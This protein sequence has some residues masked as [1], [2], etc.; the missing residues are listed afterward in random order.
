MRLDR[1][2]LACDDN[3]DFC[4]YFHAVSL[5]WKKIVNVKPTLFYIGDEHNKKL[6][7]FLGDIIIF[8]PLKDIPTPFQ[9][10][11]IRLLG[12]CL[13]EDISIISDMDILPLSNDYFQKSIKEYNKNNFIIYRPF[14]KIPEG[15][16]KNYHKQEVP[17]C[18]NAAHG[19]TWREIFKVSDIDQI[20]ETLKIWWKKD[21]R[22]TADQRILHQYLNSWENNSKNCIY[23]GDKKTNFKR[24]DRKN[25]LSIRSAAFIGNLSKFTDFH[26]P[27]PYNAMPLTLK[28][29]FWR[30]NIT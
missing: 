22:W 28:F 1:V 5:A 18:Y 9:A 7:N 17:I 24:L 20:A 30:K 8:E 3:D 15:K 25:R 4:D 19:K 10:Q 6:D 29:I 21:Q 16:G 13:F 12:P 11:C 26:V 14:D 2:I 23:L 27:R